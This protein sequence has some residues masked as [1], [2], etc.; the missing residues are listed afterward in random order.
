MIKKALIIS[1]IFLFVLAGLPGPVDPL[2]FRRLY[3][4]F[5]PRHSLA[6]GHVRAPLSGADPFAGQ[7]S[8]QFPELLGAWGPDD[9]PA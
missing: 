8:V 2:R 4:R 6:P 1:F 9:R 3:C 5:S 7:P